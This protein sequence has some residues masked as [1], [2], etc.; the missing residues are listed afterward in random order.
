MV[1]WLRALAALAE[2]MN[3]IPRTHVVAHTS[4]TPVPGT[5][6]SSSD[7]HRHQAHKRYTYIHTYT[8]M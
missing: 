8:H 4:V 1:Q 3:S 5:T 2:N 7:L 6:G